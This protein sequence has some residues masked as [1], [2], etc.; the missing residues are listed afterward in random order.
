[1][2][3]N[4]VD[5]DDVVGGAFAHAGGGDAGVAGFGAQFGEGSGSEV[6]HAALQSSDELGEDSICGGG[7]FLEGFHAFG[8]G[9]AGR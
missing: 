3:G 1:M 4:G 9:F 5:F 2:S 7:D 8:G 6:A